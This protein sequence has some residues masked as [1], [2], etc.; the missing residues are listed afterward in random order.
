MRFKKRVLHT[1]LRIKQEQFHEFLPKKV[2]IYNHEG[3]LVAYL[4]PITKSTLKNKKEIILLSKWRKDNSLAFPSQFTVTTEGTK[5]WL[6]NQLIK[7]PTRILFFVE[8]KDKS[9][10]LVGH[11]GLYGFN[12][13][14]LSCEVDNV[15]RGNKIY[16]KGAMTWGLRALIRWTLLELE[17][18]RIFLRVFSDNKHAIEFYKRCGFV[19]YKLIPLKKIKKEDAT[20]WKEDKKLKKVDKYFLK[21]VFQ[22]V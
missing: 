17:P 6:E 18:R 19:Q 10:R 2:P 13:R 15:I 8:S 9:S 1:F 20:I 4:R 16:L 7:N 21:M 5:K 22:P 3:E 11:M 12:F 14:D